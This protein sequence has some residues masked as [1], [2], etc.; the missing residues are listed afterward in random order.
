MVQDTYGEVD[1]NL[2]VVDQATR[3]ASVSGR[4]A[5][6]FRLQDCIFANYTAAGGAQNVMFSGSTGAG[7]ETKQ[8]WLI[9]CFF[10]D[11]VPQHDGKVAFVYAHLWAAEARQFVGG[12]N[13]FLCTS[14]Q[15]QWG[16]TLADLKCVMRMTCQ[17][18][19]FVA[20]EVPRTGLSASTAFAESATFRPSGFTLGWLAFTTSVISMGYATPAK[21]ARC[22]CDVSGT[23]SESDCLARRCWR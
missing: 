15:L 23:G 6:A 3:V 18:D 16:V 10:S 13:Q 7:W 5:L 1:W 19:E 8:L 22:D 21:R 12:Q 20:S 11:G 17:S 2:I 14:E 4:G 9:D